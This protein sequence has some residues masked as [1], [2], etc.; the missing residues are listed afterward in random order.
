MNMHSRCFVATAL[1]VT[2]ASSLASTA[3]ADTLRCGKKL[4][5]DGDSTVKVFDT[6]GAPMMKEQ[7]SYQAPKTERYRN[8]EGEWL[9]KETTETRS[10]EIWYYKPN[11]LRYSLRFEEGKLVSVSSE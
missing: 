11:R 2:L 1:A 9:T 7:I 10:A 8:E 4:V 6:C 3:Q 5:S